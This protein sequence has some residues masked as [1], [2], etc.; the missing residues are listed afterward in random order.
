MRTLEIA[1]L[2]FA[3]FTF[4]SG[5]AQDYTQLFI[6]RALMGPSVAA[7]PLVAYKLDP[8][9]RRDFSPAFSVAQ[10]AKDM[11]LAVA[12]GEAAGVPMP[13]AALV[14]DAFARQA[15]AGG[16][17]ELDFFAALLEAER[18]AGLGEP[19]VQGDA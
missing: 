15:G 4:L 2:W 12:A 9:R 10:M 16:L 5:L 6:C 11:S 8:L 19:A 17:A 18:Q 1:I 14:R 7:S 13:L 3:G